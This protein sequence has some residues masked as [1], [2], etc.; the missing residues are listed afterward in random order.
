MN[1]LKKIE[2]AYGDDCKTKLTDALG[3]IDSLPNGVASWEAAHGGD[4]SLANKNAEKCKAASKLLGEILATIPGSMTYNVYGLD[5][6]LTFKSIDELVKG[7]AEKG[8]KK[9]PSSHDDSHLRA[10][11]RGKPKFDK[12][13][14]P[15]YDGAGK[16]RYDTWELYNSMSN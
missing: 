2:S 16:I 5:K 6:N 4:K 9:I 15:M 14:G 11:L 12:L 13:T 10:E 3:L 8:I 7:L 1:F